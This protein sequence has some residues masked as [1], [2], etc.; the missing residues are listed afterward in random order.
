MS[1]INARLAI[2]AL[3]VS[4][5]SQST[6]LD[7]QIQN[8]GRLVTDIT[9]EPDGGFTFAAEDGVE[10]WRRPALARPGEAN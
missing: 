6:P 1:R 5:G 4:C 8:I 7:M 2:G 9:L 3:A 10:I